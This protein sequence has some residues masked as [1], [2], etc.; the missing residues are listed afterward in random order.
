EDI[1]PMIRNKFT[2]QDGS[3]GKLVVIEPPLIGDQWNINDLI[4]LISMIRNITDSVDPGA[5]VAGD[6]PVT[7]DLIGAI[8]TDAPPATLFAFLAVFLLVIVLFRRIQSILWVSLA[9]LVGVLWMAGLLIFLDI[10]INVLNFIAL[11][12]TFGIGVDYGVNIF[13]RYR[14]EKEGDIENAILHTGG[15]VGLASLTTIIGYGSLMIAGNQAFVSFGLLAVIGEV[16]CLAAAIF[17]LPAFL[18]WLQIRSSAKAT[19]K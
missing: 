4:G 12:I 5:P 16:T 6:L 8:Q 15:A 11:P 13:Q 10:K 2:E 17:T 3:V 18:R 1:P 7:A 14:T 19:P 9:L